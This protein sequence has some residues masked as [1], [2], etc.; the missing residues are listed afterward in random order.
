MKIW[1]IMA[2]LTCFT[3]SAHSGA[4]IFKW[5]DE[6]GRVHFGDRP[7]DGIKKTRIEPA[8]RKVEWSG[9][10]IKIDDRGANLSDLEMVRIQ[11]D[12][13]AVYRFFDKKLYFDI[14]KTIPVNVKVFGSKEQYIKYIGR[15][16]PSLIHTRGVYIGRKK[17]IV[18][19]M[20]KDRDGSFKTL[21]HETSHAIIQSLTPYVSSWLNEGLAENMETLTWEN[22]RL[23]LD[24][25]SENF[26]NLVRYDGK[27][28]LM[29]VSKFIAL[30]SHEWRK[31][32]VSSRYMLQTQAGELVRLLLSTAQGRSF[33]IR[34]VHAYKLGDRTL[35]SQVAEEHYFG[36]LIVLEM[37]WDKW[38]RRVG[39][40]RI[41]L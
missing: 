29:E 40:E 6:N 12:V 28:K 27:K 11:D 21:K 36:G 37:N 5:K 32:N 23:Y 22:D 31:R 20:R 15:H 34:L 30:K 38:K 7:V 19:Y 33:I 25:H 41:A 18:M 14:Y 3:V 16:A 10:K 13:N 9:F 1:T 8:V 17:Q 4:E 2:F 26:R 24:F 35:A 39:N